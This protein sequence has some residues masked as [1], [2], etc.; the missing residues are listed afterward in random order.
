MPKWS[1]AN[2]E[3]VE[4]YAIELRHQLG[5]YMQHRVKYPPT[6][7]EHIRYE[8]SPPAK[9]PKAKHLKY[10]EETLTP[11]ERGTNLLEV[12]TT[13][14]L[15]SEIEVISKKVSMNTAT[16][17]SSDDEEEAE[18]MDVEDDTVYAERHGD[19][20]E[21]SDRDKKGSRR[22]WRPTTGISWVRR[23]KRRRIKKVR[24]GRF[25]DLLEGQAI[26]LRERVPHWGSAAETRLEKGETAAGENRWMPTT[27]PRQEQEEEVPKSRLTQLW[28]LEHELGAVHHHLHTAQIHKNIRHVIDAQKNTPCFSRHIRPNGVYFSRY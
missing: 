13:A 5:Y 25:Q 28:W 4:M 23:I 18:P 11:E 12:D 14:A 17:D 6:A 27:P 1:D 21:A 19:D 7:E 15:A 9:D 24:T 8:A 16:N 2:K 3:A 22:R 10:H 26:R 20:M